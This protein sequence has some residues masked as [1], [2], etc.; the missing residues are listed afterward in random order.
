MRMR[1]PRAVQT[2]IHGAYPMA[3]S[4]AYPH[5]TITGLAR[6]IQTVVTYRRSASE[7]YAT[8]IPQ[9]I[10]GDT[11]RHTLSTHLHAQPSSSVIQS[12]AHRYANRMRISNNRRAYRVR[13]RHSLTHTQTAHTA[14]TKL[15]RHIR[16]LCTPRRQTASHIRYPAAC[17]LTN[18]HAC[19][20]RHGPTPPEPCIIR[21]QTRQHPHATR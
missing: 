8:H 7:L 21:A 6:R 4:T 18:A 14:H 19:P 2:S 3:N 15:T 13:N 5:T 12:H 10:S 17:F 11:A 20:A 16:P 1:Y 9:R